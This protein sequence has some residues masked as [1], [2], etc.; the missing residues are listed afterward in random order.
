MNMI[1]IVIIIIME[2]I[3]W[4]AEQRRETIPLYQFFMMPNGNLFGMLVRK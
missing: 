4:K 3:K 2:F 1:M